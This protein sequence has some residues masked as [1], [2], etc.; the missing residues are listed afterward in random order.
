M[1]W[2]LVGEDVINKE[3]AFNYNADATDYGQLLN[4]VCDENSDW[5]AHDKL[6]CVIKNEQAP[7]NLINGRAELSTRDIELNNI[8]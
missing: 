8:N 7:L 5:H 1:T 2:K 4:I 6:C 3:Y